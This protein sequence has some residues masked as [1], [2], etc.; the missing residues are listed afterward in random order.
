M[1]M[2]S[3][4]FFD[5]S[6]FPIEKF[7]I[8]IAERNSVAKAWR[9][10]LLLILNSWWDWFIPNDIK[11]K[12]C[13]SSQKF[14][15]ELQSFS[16]RT[17]K[18]QHYSMITEKKQSVLRKAI[19]WCFIRNQTW[20]TTSKRKKQICSKVVSQMLC[21]QLDKFQTWRHQQ[22][23]LSYGNQNKTPFFESL[24]AIKPKIWQLRPIQNS[25]VRSFANIF[26]HGRLNCTCNFIPIFW[27]LGFGFC[28]ISGG[29]F[30]N[31]LDLKKN[32]NLFKVQVVVMLRTSVN[33]RLE[34]FWC[35]FWGM[36]TV[37]ILTL[38]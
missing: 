28:E 14:F 19:L 10:F 16:Q 36:C 33:T 15:L 38:K 21:M 6:C 4:K 22:N 9:Q 5:I 18:S 13:N 30:G 8:W 25:L 11:Q 20:W 32:L 23:F 29:W 34:V 24:L 37:F 35:F 31:S 27:P 12:G 7:L 3:Q 1:I 26:F 2:I 17:L